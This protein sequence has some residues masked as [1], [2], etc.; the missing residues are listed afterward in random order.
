MMYS[1]KFIGFGFNYSD[2]F[3]EEKDLSAG[4][5]IFLEFT[6]PP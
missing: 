4:N 3:K 1:L 2:K 6:L 5:K